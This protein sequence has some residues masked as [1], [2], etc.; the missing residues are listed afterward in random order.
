MKWTVVYREAAERDLAELWLHAADR[1]ALAA[2]ADSIEK[3]LRSDPLNAGEMLT[4][5]LRIITEGPLTA[6]YKVSALDR[7]A[8]VWAVV[9][10]E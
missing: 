6:A 10:T 2:A 5:S 1:N 9:M 3:M 7:L 4:D 8:S